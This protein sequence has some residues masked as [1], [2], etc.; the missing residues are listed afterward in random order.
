MTT[1][2]RY[3]FAFV[4]LILFAALALLSGVLIRYEITGE[5][6]DGVAFL[7]TAT[8]LVGVWIGARVDRRSAKRSNGD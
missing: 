8:A 4:D 7:G 2:R 3:D 5:I 1:T 6:G